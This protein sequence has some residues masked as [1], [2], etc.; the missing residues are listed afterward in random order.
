[1]EEVFGENGNNFPNNSITYLHGDNPQQSFI[2][3]KTG[4]LS[5]VKI[6][7][8]KKSLNQLLFI[9]YFGYL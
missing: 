2:K 3:A 1:M 4:S 8:I 6:K 9:K 7:K 5:H